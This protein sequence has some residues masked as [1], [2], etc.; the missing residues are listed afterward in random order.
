MTGER[1]RG[2]L[3]AWLLRI[4]FGPA[5]AG[6][7]LLA[8]L[9]APVALPL[10]WLVAAVARRRRA[11][12]RRQQRSDG[13]VPVVVVGNLVA[14]GA[15]K[16]PL[17]AAIATGLA[18]R[19][20]RPG[21][22]ARGYRAGTTA[23]LVDRD[24]DPATLGDEAVLLAEQT[25]LPLAVGAD[26]GAALALLLTHHPDRDVVIADDG[27]QHTGLPRRLELLA[28]DRRGFGNGRCL[29]AGPLREPADRV[30]SVDAVI[31][32][33]GG[34]GS[35]GVG[36]SGS[37]S[38]DSGSSDGNASA[39]PAPALTA[40]GPRRFASR[41]VAERFRT[42]DGAAGWSPAEFVA[43]FR[44]QPITAIAGIAAPERFFTTLRELGLTPRCE[45][46]ADHARIDPHWLG[47]LPGRWLLLTAKDA[48]KCRDL[49]AATR[50]RCVRLD[51]AAQPDPA[52]L[53]WLTGALA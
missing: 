18:A 39:E 11:A 38:S 48:V 32:T 21:L 27:L 20:W 43:Q 7:R 16:T 15:G 4:W 50:A 22:L 51:V 37:G 24:G 34:A 13:A 8:A 46:L 2:R 5:T 10:S 30:A 1:L 44:D 19:G 33:G 53:E 35:S 42:L 3:E 23:A 52:L 36:F 12:L 6:D 25:G 45:P 47:A 17:V 9:V 28:I 41:L 31:D 29:P 49:P 40:A 14:G 26:R